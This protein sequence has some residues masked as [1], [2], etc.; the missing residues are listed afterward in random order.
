LTLKGLEGPHVD[1][2]II[3]KKTYISFIKSACFLLTPAVFMKIFYKEN[4][5][6]IM[7]KLLV[8]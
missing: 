7:R 5:V 2:Y 6:K 1:M 4:E 3:S 8:H